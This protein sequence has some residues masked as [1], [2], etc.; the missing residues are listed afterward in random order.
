[1]VWMISAPIIGA[2]DREASAKQR[3]AAD[4]NSED[5]VELEPE[6]GIVRV[7]AADVRRRHDA[8]ERGAEPG[9]GM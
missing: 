7:G 4:H 9:N 6:A 8:G 2:G 1:M 5:G 3:I